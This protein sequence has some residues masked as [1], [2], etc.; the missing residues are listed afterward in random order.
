MAAPWEPQEVS[1]QIEADVG[2]SQDWDD[3]DS[4]CSPG[5][6]SSST[7]SLSSSIFDYRK[8]HGRTYQSTSTTEYWAPNDEQQNEGLDLI[9]NALLIL[10]DNQLCLAPISSTSQ[11]VLDV[12]TGTGI[13]AIDFGDQYPT[14]QVI[15][16]DISPIQPTWVPPNVKFEIDD[17]VLEWSW[18]ENH[19]DLIHLRSL[20]GSIPDWGALYKKAFRHLKPGG[21]MQDIEMEVRIQSDH[22]KFPDDHIFNRWE[23]LINQAGDRIGRRFDIAKGHTMRRHMEEAGFVD[24]VERK[25]KAPLHSWPKDM[26]LRDVG[27]V[28]QTAFD[29]S[30]DGFGMF[31]FTQV[32]GLL[33]E[34][35]V[36][37]TSEMRSESRK[38]LNLHWFMVYVF[39]SRGI[40]TDTDLLRRTIVFGRKP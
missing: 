35:V 27:S 13:W 19:F 8:L 22:Y 26:K 5:S 39:L 21:W 18:P 1:L 25:I 38:R 20:Y 16:T 15:G 12:G 23:K 40:C 29:Q 3:N 34:E 11:R 4:A 37:L 24:I 6:P 17:C 31:L 14:A 9:H 28:L 7:A 2:L 10:L 30:V 36:V 32:L 33:R